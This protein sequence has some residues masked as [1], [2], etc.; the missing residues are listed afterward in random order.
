MS[1][2]TLRLKL[3]DHTARLRDFADTAALI[4]LLDLVITV[5]TSVAHL[6]GALAKP[7][8]VLL[9]KV[10]DWRGCSTARTRRGTRR[11]GC[12]GRRRR[13]IGRPS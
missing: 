11:C 3:I 9:P 2:S 4:S 7:T 5:D 1:D 6:A 10:P 8:W 12:G 13:A